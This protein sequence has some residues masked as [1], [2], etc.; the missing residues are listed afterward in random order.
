[1]IEIH[2]RE[3]LLNSLNTLTNNSVASFGKMSAQHMIE[4]LLLTVQISSNKI[5]HPCSF[6][7]EK[8]N[9]FK[10]ALIYSPAEMP[11]GFR[12]PILTEELPALTYADIKSVLTELEKELIYFEEFFQKNPTIKTTNPSLGDL[13]YTEWIIFHNKHFTHHF[14]QFN[15]I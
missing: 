2:N 5:P 14:K 7:E 6:R 10:Q 4:H 1:M 9:A 3:F 11:N 15:L 13:N 8:A 12:S